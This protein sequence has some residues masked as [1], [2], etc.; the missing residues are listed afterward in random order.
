MLVVMVKVLLLGDDDLRAQE[1]ARQTFVMV[2]GINSD[3]A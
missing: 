2:R 1:S 3:V